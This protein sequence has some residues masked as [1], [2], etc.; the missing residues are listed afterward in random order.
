SELILDTNS[1]GDELGEEDTKEDESSDADD[2]K[3]G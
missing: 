3:E 2:D 1:E